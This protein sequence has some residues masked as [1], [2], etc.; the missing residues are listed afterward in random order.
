MNASENVE[1]LFGFSGVLNPTLCVSIYLSFSL[2]PH[3][4][5]ISTTNEMKI[6]SQLEREHDQIGQAQ[7][8]KMK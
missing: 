6:N 3:L 8:T 5:V 7:T 4:L 2:F 1:H